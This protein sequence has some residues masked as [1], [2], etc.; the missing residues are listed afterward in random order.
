VQQL[1]Q[2]TPFHRKQTTTM[3]NLRNKILQHVRQLPRNT[4]RTRPTTMRGLQQMD[5]QLNDERINNM[6]TEE[7]IELFEKLI[8]KKRQE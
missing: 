8:Q 6:T 1:Q 4:T 2:K 5:E 3:R 7:A